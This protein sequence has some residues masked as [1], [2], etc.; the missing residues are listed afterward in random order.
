MLIQVYR[1]YFNKE[2]RMCYGSGSHGCCFACAGHGL[3]KHFPDENEHK[4]IVSEMRD[5]VTAGNQQ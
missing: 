2:V 5:A 1:V 3:K 4:A